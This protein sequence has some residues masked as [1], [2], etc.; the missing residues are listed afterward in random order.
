[1]ASVWKMIFDHWWTKNLESRNF[2]KNWLSYGF[3]EFGIWGIG[4]VGSIPDLETLDSLKMG[5]EYGL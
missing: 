2:M 3:G 1:M 5:L 4:M